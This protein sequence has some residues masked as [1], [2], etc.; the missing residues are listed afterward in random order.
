[1]RLI[2]AL[3]LLASINS[4]SQDAWVQI[5]SCNGPPRSVAVAFTLYD[6]GW[7]ATGYDGSGDMRSMF[8]YDLDQNDWDD[9][10]PLGG[11][12]G[13]GLARKS[14]VGFA[15]GN[16][17]FVGLGSGVALFFKDIWRYNDTTKVWTQMADFGGTARREAVAFAVDTMAYVGSGID[18][19]GVVGDFWSYE[20]KSN[21]WAPISPCPGGA[22]REAVGF[23]MGGRAYFG[24]G[25]GP[26]GM[27]SDFWEYFP[28]TDTWTEKAEFPGGARAGATGIA[29]FPQAFI[30][31]GEDETFTYKDDV[32]EYNYFGDVWTQRADFP[33]G[34]RTQ[35]VAFNVEGRLFVGSGYDGSF[36]DDFYEYGKLA[37]TDE[38]IEYDLNIYPNPASTDI[39]IE[40]PESLLGSVFALYDQA[41]RQMTAG[42][43]GDSKVSLSVSNF[44]AGTYYLNIKNYLSK[45]LVIQ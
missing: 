11:S 14:A 1:M 45:K 32:W 30:M 10:E 9:E 35:A 25:I 21:T 22:R 40:V 2:L 39:T 19:T 23:T 13:S 34:G 36:H 18:E 7:V 37:S 16:Y 38:I 24:T 15:V 29:E 41:G 5:D 33:A 44:S 8:S 28:P 4:Y 43:L 3:L 6:E 42:V 31:L 17:G 20:W 27:L 12:T 26:T